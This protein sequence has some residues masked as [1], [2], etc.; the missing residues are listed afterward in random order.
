MIITIS[1]TPGAGDTTVTERLAEELGYEV[2][3]V[4][5][6]Y[7]ELA[8][9]K[10]LE[11]GELWE[12]HEENPEKLEKFHKELDEKQKNKTRE[13]ENLIING[14]LS[15]F[16][17]E[18]ADLKVF[19]TAE[20]E[21][22]ARRIAMRKKM[23]REEFAEK[24]NKGE[25]VKEKLSKEEL[26]EAKEEI[27]KRQ[28]KEIKHWEKLYGI[29]YIEDRETYDLIIDTTDKKPKQVFKIIKREINKI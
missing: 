28:R 14:K 16:K 25:E 1:G 6:I 26:E 3:K 27:R 19:L 10:G 23:G 8:R 7:K 17:I 21:E 9:E 18:E 24:V 4:G 15:A 12:K 13:K 29:N 22:R 20:I 11:P 2:T 5:E